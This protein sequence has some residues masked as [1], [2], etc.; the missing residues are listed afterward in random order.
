MNENELRVSLLPPLAVQ[1]LKA[2]LAGSPVGLIAG[3]GIFPVAFARAAERYQI[4]IVGCAHL[5]ETD[6]QLS[7][8]V[9]QLT[10]VK[11]GQLGKIISTFK[12]AGVRL[13]VFAGGINRVRLFGGVRLDWRALQVLARVRCVKDDALLRALAQEMESEGISV[14]SATVLL[15]ELRMP[16]GQL[17]RWALSAEQ[18]Q[19][20]MI[21]WQAAKVL[22]E[23]DLGQ[24]VAVSKGSVVALEAVE[25]TDA[26]IRRAAQIAGPGITVVKVFKPGQDERFDL[27]AVGEH[28]VHTLREVQAGALVVEAEKSLLLEHEKVIALANAS[29]IALRAISSIEELQSAVP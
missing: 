16:A 8:L 13:V 1:Q 10:W 19:D 18:V 29:K 3:N 2:Q 11:V 7:S 6:D 24:T 15:D 17:G 25:G 5:G 26:C 14:I 12:R 28:T 20:A 27:P 4:P 9:S 23:L 21:G 22:G